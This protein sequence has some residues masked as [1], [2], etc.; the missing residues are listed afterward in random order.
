MNGKMGIIL[1]VCLTAIIALSGCSSMSVTTLDKDGKPV[2]IENFSGDAISMISKNLQHKLVMVTTD[3]I[4]IDFVI[5]PPT[6][7]NPTGA[8]KATYAGGKKV[9]LTIPEGFKIDKDGFEAL[10]KV[11]E[12]TS[13]RSVSITPTGV[14]TK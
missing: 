2:V 7:E 4:Y 10:A 3:G 11:I 8:I 13:G 5:E 1:A 12:A 9:Y 6:Q 14:V